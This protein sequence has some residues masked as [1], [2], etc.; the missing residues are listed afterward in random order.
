[1]EEEPRKNHIGIWI[2]SLSSMEERFRNLDRT[3]LQSGS[4][5]KL[6]SLFDIH[7]HTV[8]FNTRI[9]VEKNTVTHTQLE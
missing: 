1:M 4:P 9:H 6:R 3:F 5:P 2:D 8:L 7:R